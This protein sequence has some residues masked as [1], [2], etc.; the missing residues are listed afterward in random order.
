MTKDLSSGQTSAAEI[1]C[2]L[3]D[4]L[5]RDLIGPGP[6]DPD[7]SEERL[8]ENPSRS[9][10]AGFLTP[11]LDGPTDGAEAL[12][13]EGDPLFGED[14]AAQF[15]PAYRTVEWQRVAGRAV[16]RMPVPE[17]G[18]GDRVVVPG[19]AGAQRPSGAL[20]LEAH[21]RPYTIDQPDGQR[22]LRALTV[23]V[24]NR[25]NNADLLPWFVSSPTTYMRAWRH[26]A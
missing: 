15:D 23:M 8:K 16:L 1:R 7:L 20:T 5:R 25:R 17:N 10:L 18:R 4:A 14:E 9:Y 12:E 26:S 19:S 22:H 13:D 21:A 24:V 2:R 11:A 6:Q 3:V